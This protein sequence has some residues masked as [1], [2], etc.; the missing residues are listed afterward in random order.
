MGSLAIAYPFRH[1]LHTKLQLFLAFSSPQHA[2]N[3]TTS[4]AEFRDNRMGPGKNR[5][6]PCGAQLAADALMARAT[7]H[8]MKACNESVQRFSWHIAGFA[9]AAGCNAGPPG[10]HGHFQ[11]SVL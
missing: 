2:T 1:V 11:E 9:A 4:Y 8:S 6:L 5:S 7:S 10:V 3:A